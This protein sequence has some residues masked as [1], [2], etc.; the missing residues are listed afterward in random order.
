M[1]ETEEALD[2]VGSIYDAALDASLWPRVVELACRF[3]N[4]VSGALASFD[5]VH[6]NLNVE[7]NWGYDPY[8]LKLL[9]EHYVHLNPLMAFSV[10]S[11]VG[12]VLSP[13][14]VMSYE[15]LTDTVFWREWAAP[16]GFVD[17][18]QATLEKTPTAVAGLTLVR[19]ESVG[20]VNAEMVRRTRMLYPH[21]RRAV[22]IGKVID[23]HKVEAATFADTIDGLVA[24]I[25]LVEANGRVVYANPSGEAMLEE[26][27]LFEPGQLGLTA[28]D[29][30]ADRALREALSA[31]Q[32]D[33]GQI[34][35]SGIAVPLSAAS[36]AQYVA[37]VLPLT[38]G[39]RR[40]A[41]LDYA[42]VAAIFVRKAALEPE[43]AFETM[44]QKFHLTPNEVRVLQALVEINGAAAIG[45][46]LGM[47]ESTVKTHL[48]HLFEK[49][50]AERQA[51][52]IR[53]VAGFASPL[54][55]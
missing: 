35:T 22:L 29:T 34:G 6:R 28:R 52:L 15:E 38:S 53:L 19:H 50:G 37:H 10:K 30:E 44:Q 43:S 47:S 17:A 49:T 12:D 5:T 54:G 23:L 27:E 24:G 55:R 14:D 45:A 9:L 41:G 26:R 11:N 21:L 46:V 20:M 48:H 42:A 2:L 8:Y 33:E 16:Q 7:A 40:R 31:C 13:T 1:S 36:G 51:D 18:L 3:T 32:G 4:S 25:F 39:A